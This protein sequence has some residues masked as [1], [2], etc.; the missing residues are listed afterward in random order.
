MIRNEKQFDKKMD[1]LIIAV[2]D[3]KND[4][5]KIRAAALK[6]AAYKN[7]PKRAVYLSHYSKALTWANSFIR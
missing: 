4:I 3:A 1:S 6:M 7:S 2:P 5:E